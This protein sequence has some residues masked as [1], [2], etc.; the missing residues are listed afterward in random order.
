MPVT[1]TTTITNLSGKTTIY[2]ALRDKLGREPTHA[3]LCDDVRRI[4]QEVTVDMATRGK[5]PHQRR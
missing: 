5:L 4:L 3:E 2:S 1:V